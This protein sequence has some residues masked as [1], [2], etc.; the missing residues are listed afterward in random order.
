MKKYLANGCH[1]RSYTL[2][3]FSALVVAKQNRKEY[4][5]LKKQQQQQQKK[6]KQQQKKQKKKTPHILKQPTLVLSASQQATTRW[7]V[8]V[9]IKRHQYVFLLLHYEY[10]TCSVFTFVQYS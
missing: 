8:A 1:G 5:C 10:L 2:Y 3:T 9:S 7:L 6:K 4:N